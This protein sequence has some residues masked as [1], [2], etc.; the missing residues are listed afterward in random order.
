MANN[1]RKTGKSL[2]KAIY[3]KAKLSN[4]VLVPRSV[5]SVHIL[6]ILELRE[7]E[8]VVDWHCIFHTIFATYNS[9]VKDNGKPDKLDKI[10]VEQLADNA[11]KYLNSLPLNYHF[12]MPLPSG[13]ELSKPILIHKNI[14]IGRLS[15]RQVDK[16]TKANP[17]SDINSSSS[18]SE[19]M[20]G[21]ISLPSGCKRPHIHDT[22]LNIKCTGYVAH[23]SLTVYEQDPM[24]V[25]K[26]L[27]S[28]YLV[29]GYLKPDYGA[30]ISSSYE[31][32]FSA[33]E[34]KAFNDNYGYV[35]TVCRPDDESRLIN[36]HK[37]IDRDTS[38]EEFANCLKSLIARQKDSSNERLRNQVVNSLFW[39]FECRKTENP[40]MQT[41][42]FTSVLDSYFDQ[43][44]SKENKA[45]IIA[46][47]CSETT[48]QQKMVYEEIVELYSSR[49]E[50][51]HGNRSLLEYQ[52]GEKK[53]NEKARARMDISM[54]IYFSKLIES[55]LCRY[56]KSV[57]A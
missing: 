43:S 16:Y 56:V 15:Q 18:L 34:F 37:F 14:T 49:N 45:K 57:S 12:L 24:Y 53:N 7:Y 25:Y 55:K 50:I 6:E 35:T 48:Q 13:L 32:E 3:T 26:I 17:D 8:E 30:A 42:L 10:A 9:F 41:V 5:N 2:L 19:L 1:N 28:L 54:P 31:S 40:N 11:D 22:Y 44:D 27:F 52:I 4:G 51:I 39:Y 29:F 47:E 36:T 20:T 38:F 46:L 21:G 33:F 23:G